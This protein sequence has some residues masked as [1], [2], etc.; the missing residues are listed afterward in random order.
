MNII[1]WTV[2]GIR[3]VVKQV[4]EQGGELLVADD[5]LEVQ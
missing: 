2:N 3:A 1:S 4:R 5:L